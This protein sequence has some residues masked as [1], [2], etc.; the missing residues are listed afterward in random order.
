MADV[1]KSTASYT[2]GLLPL[3]KLIALLQYLNILTTFPQNDMALQSS[4]PTY[5]M[6]CVLKSARAGE[7][8]TPASTAL[9][10]TPLMLRYNCGYTPVGVFPSMITSLVS[11]QLEL[12]E[13]IDAELRKNRVQFHV[14][15]D[16][17]IVTFLLH[18]QFIEIALSRDHNSTKAFI[19]STQSVCANLRSVV[20][21]TLEMVTSHMNSNFNMG[22]Q[23]GFECPAHPGR[24][25][26]CVEEEKKMK[27]LLNPKSKKAIEM[28]PQREI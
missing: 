20:K 27:C 18:P 24:Q 12:W 6:P 3:E 15:K 2:N 13:I 5:F 17:D 1:Q 14:G 7:F 16:Y 28:D 26:L 22:Y 19:E 25:H 9:D 8:N 4:E 23:F 11:Q 21:S 10:P